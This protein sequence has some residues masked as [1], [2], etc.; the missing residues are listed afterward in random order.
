MTLL[1]ANSAGHVIENLRSAGE[2]G[3]LDTE[4]NVRNA[5]LRWCT[6]RGLRPNTIAAKRGAL[7]RFARAVSPTLPQDASPI[8]VQKWYETVGGFAQ[9][10]NCELSHVRQ[11]FLYLMREGYRADD[12]TIRLMAP[13]IRRRLPRPI[14]D[15]DLRKA[16]LI[17]PEPI[18][19]WILFGALAGLR[20]CEIAPLHRHD[21][22]T[23]LRTPMLY[24]REGKGGRDR[25]VP[26]HPALTE[27]DLPHHGYLW[28]LDG[29]VYKAKQVVQ[30]INTFF[31]S[32]GIH[33]TGHQL[34]HYFCTKYYEASDYD[35][36]STQEV[37]GHLDPSHTAVYTAW[38]MDRAAVAIGKIEI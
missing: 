1:F 6:A 24:V 9:H 31:R 5:H 33:A 13:K 35:L 29:G 30:R 7:D 37:M 11:F 27:L 19:S 8:E 15:G 2:R 4:V 12:P 26:L 32:A 17:A 34:R 10:R 20:S 22:M 28:E 3:A 25:T 18:R 21:V 36:R 38:S 16:L 23:D 14:G